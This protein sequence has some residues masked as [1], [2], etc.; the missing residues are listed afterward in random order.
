[1]MKEKKILLKQQL[2]GHFYS[3]GK[4]YASLNKSKSLELQKNLF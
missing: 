1:M 2:L 4:N 3:G